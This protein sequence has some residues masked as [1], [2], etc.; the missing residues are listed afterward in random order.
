MKLT[1]SLRAVC[2]FRPRRSNCIIILSIVF[3]R[4]L[5]ALP[6]SVWW[7]VAR[8]VVD[9]VDSVALQG[10]NLEVDTAELDN[11]THSHH[12]LLIVGE[13]VLQH[14]INRAFFSND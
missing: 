13:E 7:L 4:L 14:L 3:L 12:L 5:R 6:C 2:L 1:A 9:G 11:I 8:A 10:G